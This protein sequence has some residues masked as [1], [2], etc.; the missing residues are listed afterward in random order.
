MWALLATAE[1]FC[2]DAGYASIVTAKPEGTTH[3]MVGALTRHYYEKKP[4][5]RK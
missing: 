2:R 3:K 5:T 1:S 4:D